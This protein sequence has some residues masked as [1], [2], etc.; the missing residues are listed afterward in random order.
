MTQITYTLP[1]QIVLNL[2]S[3]PMLQGIAFGVYMTSAFAGTFLMMEWLDIRGSN[4][5]LSLHLIYTILS[6]FILGMEMKE[7]LNQT[8]SYDPEQVQQQ[9]NEEE[10]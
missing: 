4:Y 9:E 2:P 10:E 7:A 6:P 1:E 5:H 8:G 3:G